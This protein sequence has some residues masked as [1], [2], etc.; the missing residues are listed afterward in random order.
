L[1]GLVVNLPAQVSTK[2]IGKR[3][4]RKAER[5]VE[6]KIDDTI[7]KGFDKVESLF[8]KKKKR[9]ERLSAEDLIT[10]PEAYEITPQTLDV[11]AANTLNFTGTL[12]F[13]VE[14]LE[15]DHPIDVTTIKVAI[16]NE[17]IAVQTYRQ[18]FGTIR[19]IINP[20]EKTL[21]T[22]IEK[23][24]EY[25]GVKRSL[26]KKKENT[27]P[28]LVNVQK[29]DEAKI[30][31]DLVCRKYHMSHSDTSAID[32]WLSKDIEF[33][34]YAFLQKLDAKSARLFLPLPNPIE[35]IPMQQ[36]MVDEM[37][38]P[39]ARSSIQDLRMS[40][41]EPAMFSTKGYEIVDL[42]FSYD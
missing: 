41:I 20:K 10:D 15:D 25:K 4:K 9:E 1:I 42:T 40:I 2:K 29:T 38:D 17:A 22:L 39:T 37:G 16:S 31:D 21:I 27:A 34:Y 23:Y 28:I 35:G 14:T 32:L 26:E 12:E 6:N 33:N 3:T 24:G 11:V 19:T 13:Y 36:I 18:E 8:N 30:I 5:K 7:D